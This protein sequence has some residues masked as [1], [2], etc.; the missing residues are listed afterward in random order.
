M[1]PETQLSNRKY[2]SL[3]VLSLACPAFGQL[4]TVPILR[5]GD[6]LDTGEVYLGSSSGGFDSQG[7]IFT[8]ATLDNGQDRNHALMQVV[9]GRITIAVRERQQVPGFPADTVFLINQQTTIVN[10]SPEAAMFTSFIEGPFIDSDNDQTLWRWQNGE[11]QL[12]G[13]ESGSAFELGP[14]VTFRE[15]PRNSRLPGSPDGS[16]LFS[17]LLQGAGV[18]DVNRF[19]LWYAAPGEDPAL[20]FRSGVDKSAGVPSGNPNNVV[21]SLSEQGEVML[22][23]LI[24]HLPDSDGTYAIWTG[25]PGAFE[26]WVG[27]GVDIL[28]HPGL[29]LGPFGPHPTLPLWTRDGSRVVVTGLL[30]GADPSEDIAELIVSDQGVEILAREGQVPPGLPRTWFYRTI[31]M[32]YSDS[33]DYVFAGLLRGDDVGGVNEFT[34]WHRGADG[35]LQKILRADDD[36]SELP[37]FRYRDFDIV[38]IDDKGVVFI[39]T[40]IINFRDQVF[41]ALLAF[42]PS[43]GET[44][45]LLVQGDDYDIGGEI[46][47]VSNIG[48][49]RRR[50]SSWSDYPHPSVSVAWPNDESG[51]F[52]LRW[53]PCAGDL[54]ESASPNHPYRGFPDGVVDSE[55]FFFYLDAFSTDE[56][57]VCDMDDDGDCDADDFFS[58]L[59]HFANGCP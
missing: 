25:F 3:L 52:H 57:D 55:D 17:A 30:Q 29:T 28:D 47:Q 9:G 13:Q 7:S 8:N 4:E 20:L 26:K 34:A 49:P 59:D 15:I 45:V 53:P 11:L 31:P 56:L 37:G 41:R 1:I 39:P 18:T 36:I 33:G 51:R 19:T 6:V 58:Y 24:Q 5:T 2:A 40:E 42:T 50:S 35:T 12:L 54:T 10:L 44:Q 38:L 14:D 27:E 48:L 23:G 16:V 21:Y 46:V 22:A 43:T 32:A